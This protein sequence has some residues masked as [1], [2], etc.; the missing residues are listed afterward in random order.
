[1]LLELFYNYKIIISMETSNCMLSSCDNEEPRQNSRYTVNIIVARI[2]N[3]LYWNWIPNR[4]KYKYYFVGS[5]ILQIILNLIFSY[6]IHDKQANPVSRARDKWFILLLYF[7]VHVN[8]YTP[9]KVI[10]VVI[11]NTPYLRDS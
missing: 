9:W 11:M 4:M 2:L 8:E 10:V 5:Y 6:N 7:L 3:V 1:M